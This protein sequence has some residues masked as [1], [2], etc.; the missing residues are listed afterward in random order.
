MKVSAKYLCDLFFKIFFQILG[1]QEFGDTRARIREFV[2]DHCYDCMRG[3]T[4]LS[5]QVKV[6]IHP[7]DTTFKGLETDLYALQ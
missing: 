2:F 4:A 5:S 3:D 7:T 6:S 1:I